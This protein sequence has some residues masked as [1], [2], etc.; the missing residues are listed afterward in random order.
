MLVG[1]KMRTPPEMKQMR[2]A[3]L[4]WA[5][6]AVVGAMETW[7]KVVTRAQDLEVSTVK[8]CC[9]VIRSPSGRT[10][11]PAATRVGL[12]VIAGAAKNIVGA[13]A[14]PLKVKSGNII[15]NHLR[16]RS[17]RKGTNRGC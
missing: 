3:V 5:V 11:P 2:K 7:V 12:E 1:V 9:P 16:I 4:S 8:N 14:T 13:S 6:A 17:G 10:V 15:F